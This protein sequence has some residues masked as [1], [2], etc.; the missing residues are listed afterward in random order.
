MATN[1]LSNDKGMTLS[2]QDKEAFLGLIDDAKN[3]KRAAKLS[4]FEFV[5]DDIISFI[6]GTGGE[7]QSW[8][9][10]VGGAHVPVDVIDTSGNVVFTVPAIL[11]RLPTAMP[12]GQTETI[13]EA[14]RRATEIGKGNPVAARNVLVNSFVTNDHTFKPRSDVIKQWNV[15]LERYGEELIEYEADEITATNADTKSNI[16]DV[17][18]EGEMELA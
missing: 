5:K 11:Q 6:K 1:I 16:D 4:F 2:P 7:V 3:L 18:D 9:N 14:S 12:N 8:V 10:V 13:A 15:I 17:F